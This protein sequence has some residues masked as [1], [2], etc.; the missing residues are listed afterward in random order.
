MRS[1]VSGLF[2]YHLLPLLLYVC[3]ALLMTWPAVLSINTA[4]PGDGIDSFQNMWNMWWLKQALLGRLNPYETPYLY[5]PH[6]AS[7]LL[8][9]LNP[10][11]G[12]LS[13]PIHAIFGLVVAYNVMVFASLALS[14]YAAYLLAYDVIR[15]RLPALIAGT[16]FLCS[17]YMLAQAMNHLNLV[18]AEFLIFAIL[19]VRRALATP[20]WSR[21]ALATL[22][23]LITILGDWQYFLF[24]VLWAT[25]YM[26]A[27]LWKKR[28][29]QTLLP[30]LVAL[31]MAGILSL[32]LFLPTARLAANTPSADTGE[33][34]R[35]K[36]SADL[37][38]LLIPSN[39]HSFFGPWATVAQ[40]YKADIHPENK[41]A[42]L[43]IVLLSLAIFGA[44]QRASRFWL[45]TAIC[46]ALLALGPYLQI[47]G[48]L[49][50]IPL[51]AALLYQVF[52]IRISRF[53]ERFIVVSLLA[54]AV[55]AA[56]GVRRLLDL[57]A[58]HGRSPT[59]VRMLTSMF[60]I[61]LL[62][63]DNLPVPFPV[64]GIYIPPVYAAL[65]RDSERYALYEAPV[66]WCSRSNYLLYQTV[67][68]KP[69]VG[70]YLSRDLPYPLIEQI[71]VI[72]MFAYAEPAYDIIAQEPASIAASV[73]SYF[74]IRYLFLHSDCGG[75]RYNTLER[76]ALAAAGGKQPQQVR[77]PDRSF[78]IYTIVQPE[79]ARPFLGIGAGWAEVERLPQGKTQRQLDQAGELSIYTAAAFSGTLTL[80]LDNT[81]SGSL[82][83]QSASITE[84]RTVAIQ[85]G[86]QHIELPL[87][88]PAGEHHIRLEP[89]GPG[90]VVVQRLD[91][92]VS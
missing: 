13:L 5:Y 63:L 79:K 72:R 15:D 84:P 6:G 92:S 66:Y 89:D 41:T 26:L 83:I 73:F 50:A 56:F 1:R 58:A 8:H 76:V 3:L 12:F 2:S 55:V 75:L 91:L 18:S 54:F 38:D 30:G 60:L 35:I 77:I 43:G 7:L 86:Q 32:P 31:G 21:I 62:I 48:K 78:A 24:A 11:N 17:G 44:W 10:I 29:L 51:P 28:R 45:A 47:A 53:P 57:L 82:T 68:A 22:C 81:A 9:T 16:A 14:G 34:F 49:T 67:H 25:W 46:F 36:Y 70:G 42:Y 4:V 23:L 69:I 87:S 40:H 71:P 37:L 64:T 27:L 33:A 65:S 59:R 61:G 52:F 80:D 39:L 88:L 74:N 19:A 20:H 85:A 90:R